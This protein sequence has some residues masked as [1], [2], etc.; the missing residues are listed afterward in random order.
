MAYS[1]VSPTFVKTNKYI[2]LCELYYFFYYKYLNCN[3]FFQDKNSC[4]SKTVWV[5]KESKITLG[6]K[7][8][9]WFN[10]NTSLTI[11]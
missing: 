7:N 4:L 8:K 10:K 1:V 5:C 3:V 9:M 11:L 6:M 2:V